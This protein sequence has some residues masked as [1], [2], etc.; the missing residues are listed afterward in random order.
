MPTEELAVDL[1]VELAV[2]AIGSI[3]PAMNSGPRQQVGN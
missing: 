3:K 2:A 1:W